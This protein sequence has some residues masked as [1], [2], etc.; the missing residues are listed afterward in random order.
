MRLE[1]PLTERELL[2]AGRS[3]LTYSQR[4][5]VGWV[6]MF[7]FALSWVFSRVL[8]VDMSI[9]NGENLGRTMG[10]IM[11][12]IQFFA[13]YFVSSSATTSAIVD[14]RDQ[15]TLELLALADPRGW[16]IALSKWAAAWLRSVL[17]ILSVL[18]MFAMVG[19]L[20]GIDAGVMT[21]T[22]MYYICIAAAVAAIGIYASSVSKD[23][24]N[25]NALTVF[26]VLL[27]L[28]CAAVID[29]VV[30]VGI[31]YASGFD[32]Y[33][34]RLFG[35]IPA[36]FG[37]PVYAAA[38]CVLVLGAA[39]RRI[40]EHVAGAPQEQPEE[41]EYYPTPR[42]RRAAREFERPIS[43]L[44][45]KS[46]RVLESST[47]LLSY[48]IALFLCILL[49]F[50][51][52][53]ILGGLASLDVARTLTNLKRSGAWDDL[54]VARRDDASFAAEV[55]HGLRKRSEVLTGVAC[56]NLFLAWLFFGFPINEW[57]LMFLAVF[58]Y[59]RAA[60]PCAALDATRTGPLSKRAQRGGVTWL[61]TSCV[62]I[63]CPLPIFRFGP[64][65]YEVTGLEL[66]AVQ[67][68]FAVGYV[69]LNIMAPLVIAR[70]AT[71]RFRN[72]CASMPGDGETHADYTGAAA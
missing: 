12:T 62:V 45:A 20:G 25:A 67:G 36:W 21:A 11:Q 69:L 35:S 39:S 3:K 48:V 24:S 8:D 64:I 70:V 19:F 61:T 27:W 38:T 2:I 28:A 31:G 43:V 53:L 9:E 30:G 29:R 33:A 52:V 54:L 14:E 49:P 7:P 22:T 51:G 46:S 16:D 40:R 58:L 18:P 47:Y 10:W 42:P 15:R 13:A 37:L 57:L 6:L 65:V 26:L 41:S 56:A 17:L 50:V 63:L 1:W 72:R 68:V 4:S 66:P 23:V 34:T 5:A 60:V 55:L 59:Y 71:T 32:L 44:V